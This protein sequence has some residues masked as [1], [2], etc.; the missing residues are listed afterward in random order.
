MIN[1]LSFTNNNN[2]NAMNRAHE[3]TTNNNV[4]NNNNAMN[5][6]FSEKQDSAKSFSFNDA[7]DFDTNSNDFSFDTQSSFFLFFSFS[8]Q[9]SFTISTSV[10]TSTQFTAHNLNQISSDIEQKNFVDASNQS[11]FENI[12]QFLA[13]H[14]RNFDDS[15]N[16]LFLTSIKKRVINRQ[17][18]QLESSLS[19]RRMIRRSIF[20]NFSR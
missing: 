7:D 2:N 20:K 18:R 1:A 4:N 12:D 6:A 10:S 3:I 15:K 19:K 8:F 17:S 11:S 13:I 16:S 5:R 14:V 9:S